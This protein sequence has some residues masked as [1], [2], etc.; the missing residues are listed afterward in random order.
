M[1]RPRFLVLV[2]VL[3]L[4]AQA[5]TAA[6]AE[7]K[8]V[9]AAGVLIHDL[10]DFLPEIGSSEGKADDPIPGFSCKPDGTWSKYK[11]YNKNGS[12]YLSR[13]ELAAIA[14]D[15]TKSLRE[16]YPEIFADLDTDGDE[17]IT[18]AELQAYLKKPK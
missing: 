4:P 15:L 10:R 12:G 18:N 13:V 5:A 17:K 1:I 2:L 8:P 6:D 11:A 3:V 16:R 14:S 7:E 9:P